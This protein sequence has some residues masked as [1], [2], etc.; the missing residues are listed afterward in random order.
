MR[1]P[2]KKEDRTHPTQAKEARYPLQQ[3]NKMPKGKIDIPGTLENKDPVKQPK[4]PQRQLGSRESK[5]KGGRTEGTSNRLRRYSH[6][7]RWGITKR[8][9][10]EFFGW[11]LHPY[12][13]LHMYVHICIGSTDDCSRIFRTLVA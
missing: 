1:T 3:P 13:L 11:D 6:W 10:L 8:T 5:T 2:K 7:L 4:R 9:K 12:I